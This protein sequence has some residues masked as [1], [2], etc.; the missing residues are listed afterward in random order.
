MTNYTE[1]GS[2]TPVADF[3]QAALQY[4]NYE[5]PASPITIPLRVLSYRG[6]SRARETKALEILPSVDLKTNR[7]FNSPLISAGKLSFPKIVISGEIDTPIVSTATPLPAVI[8]GGQN[9]TYADV[10]AA[11]LEGRI[12]SSIPVVTD[13]NW[14]RDPF[15][16]T[17]SKVRVESFDAAFVEAVPGR[18]TFNLTLRVFG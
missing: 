6:L 16:R 15:G 17:F 10:I 1:W 7:T 8:L 9:V 18:T 11:Y 13:P 14:F 2:A 4:P 3:R 5:T 12:Y